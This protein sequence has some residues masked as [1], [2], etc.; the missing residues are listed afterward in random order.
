MPDKM[1]RQS[2]ISMGLIALLGVLVA[3]F[4]FPMPQEPTNLPGGQPGFGTPPSVLDV[5]STKSDRYLSALAGFTWYAAMR[6]HPADALASPEWSDV[7]AEGR[8]QWLQRASRALGDLPIEDV[9]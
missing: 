4:V 3:V 2:W 1:D 5:S 8:R 9:S 6:V 7:S